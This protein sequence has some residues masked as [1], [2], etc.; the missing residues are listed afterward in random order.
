M[1]I[2][3]QKPTAK[4]HPY[5]PSTRR[6]QLV[7]EAAK[8]ATS[9]D[10]RGAIP[11]FQFKLNGH[12]ILWDSENGFVHFTGI[13]KALGNSKASIV[14]IIAE[15]PDLQVKK[16]RGGCLTIQGTWMPY[17]SARA[18]CVKNAWALRFDL[19][20]VFGKSFPND[21]C[22]P[23]HPDFGSLKVGSALISGDSQFSSGLVSRSS[24][25]SRGRASSASGV[26]GRH[27]KASAS[28]SA[29]PAAATTTTTTSPASAS[30]SPGLRSHLVRSCVTRN[31]KGYSPYERASSPRRSARQ[32]EHSLSSPSC[33]SASGGRDHVVSSADDGAA[34]RT[35]GGVV[36]VRAS[37]ASRASSGSPY[38][39]SSSRASSS[40]PAASSSSCA[41]PS[42]LSRRR[43]HCMSIQSLLNDDEEEDCSLVVPSALFWLGLSSPAPTTLP[44]MVIPG[45][46]GEESSAFTY[47]SSG[48][49]TPLPTAKIVGRGMQRKSFC[50]GGSRPSL[51]V[52]PETVDS[53]SGQQET[54]TAAAEIV[55]LFGPSPSAPP[56]PV[57]AS[58]TS[59][60]QDV[61]E[62][63]EAGITLQCLSQHDGR[64]PED[65]LKNRSLP[66]KVRAGNKI[67]HVLWG[68]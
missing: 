62:R 44:P 16:V 6:F 14:K 45:F 61:I 37:R 41:S 59:Q 26:S 30:A 46:E 20:S 25:P 34:C 50:R 60:E 12:T 32:K 4:Y 40:S 29:T 10:S 38:P 67:F 1:K 28:S 56:L 35:A 24:R 58:L 23:G 42:V 8:Y 33:P 5:A 2:Q 39:A 17:E 11:V 55:P 31:A 52:I 9:Q 3:Q 7:I 53:G 19:V 15:N 65:F 36:R 51:Q 21:C 43:H 66:T 22:P 63:V 18:L 64:R 13:W 54:A 49:L 48:F 27:T 57:P 68:N 47:D